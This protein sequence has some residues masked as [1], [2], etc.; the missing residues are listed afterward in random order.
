MITTPGYRAPEII[1]GSK[2]YSYSVDRW[3][4]TVV[5]GEIIIRTVNNRERVFHDE[6]PELNMKYF[7]DQ[8]GVR[9]RDVSKKKQESDEQGK[10]IQ[11]YVAKFSCTLGDDGDCKVVTR[12]VD[13]FTQIPPITATRKYMNSA[14]QTFLAQS[15]LWQPRKRLL[16]LP[17]SFWE[18]LCKRAYLE[19][20]STKRAIGKPFKLPTNRR[21]K[22]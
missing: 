8:L 22:K 10:L 6:K 1:V 14:L 12:I 4:A 7:R 18:E 13:A 9:P 19:P 16:A 21:R 11:K 20:K 3:A 15:F 2:C 17:P 5:M